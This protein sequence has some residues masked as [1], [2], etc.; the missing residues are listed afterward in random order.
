MAK[1]ILTAWQRLTGLLTLDKKDIFQIF[2][3]AIFADQNYQHDPRCAYSGPLYKIN[4][5][6]YPQWQGK[7]DQSGKNCIVKYLKNVFLVQGQKSR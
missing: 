1:H 2:Y 5:G 3:Y 4:Y 6:L 7:V